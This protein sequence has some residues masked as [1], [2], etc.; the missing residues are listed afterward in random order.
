KANG[1]IKDKPFSQKVFYYKN[2][3][4]LSIEEFV[5]H[6]G[7]CTVWNETEI[8]NRGQKMAEVAFEYIWKF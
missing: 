5:K 2:L 1:R 8:M 4:S 6:H 3:H 7:G